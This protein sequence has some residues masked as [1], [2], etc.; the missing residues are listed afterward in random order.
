VRI[1]VA[2]NLYPP[3][4]LGGYEL[5]CRQV[6][7]ALR[8]AGH[9]VRVLTS[10]PRVPVTPEPHVRR[11][12]KL[13]DI[14]SQYVFLRSAPVTSHLAQSESHR[15]SAHNVHVL[16]AELDDFK[17]DVVYLWMLGG[18][19]G[20]GLL[21]SLHHVRM[22]WVWHLM[23]DV[24]LTLCKL[25]DLL[26]P[27]FVR[28]F[29][30]QVEGHYIACSRQL[31]DE[32]E[33]AGLRLNG[34][35]EVIPNWVHGPRP[36]PR[37]EHL[38]G[39]HLR[40]VSA[41]GLIDRRIDKG[42]DLLVGSA[43]RLRDLGHEDFSV[44]VFGQVTDA[45]VPD[46]IRDYGLD[47]HIRLL[48]PRTQAELAGLYADYDVF[49]FPTRPR[50]PFGFAP[51]E[52]AASGCVPVMSHTCGI[53]EWLVHGVHALKAP[54]TADAFARAFAAILDGRIEL[55]PIG[56]RAAEAVRCDF[57]LDAIL[58][59]IEATLG[60]ASAGPRDGAGTPA[61]AYRLALLAEKLSRVLIQENLC[62]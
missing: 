22:P 13:T 55:A 10:A 3:D 44:D 57:H 8:E 60:R 25:A 47:R 61:E 34:E 21:A 2:S 49:A 39:G 6:V 15:I 5:G 11:T 24:P 52:A 35:V 17:P 45:Y 53:A 58:P 48:G 26:V 50:E 20:L 40:I 29:N 33:S 54:R 56:R 12:L 31:V 32:I 59:R 23:D 51:L 43:A 1:L 7:E 4:V 19:G 18:L 46:L 42:I 27:A 37:R 28:E 14:W 41:A 62:A 16:L 9:E 36:E 30:R 38:G